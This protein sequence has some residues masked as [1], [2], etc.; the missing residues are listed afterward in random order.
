L[1]RKLDIFL[2]WP[3]PAPDY[4]PLVPEDDISPDNRLLQNATSGSDTSSSSDA[5]SNPDGSSTVDPEPD[6][7]DEKSNEDEP[8]IVEREKP[9]YFSKKSCF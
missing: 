8:V 4:S 3:F 7:M 5:S 2:I 9:K 1:K 6:V